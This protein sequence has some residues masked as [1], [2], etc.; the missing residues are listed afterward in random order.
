M[1]ADGRM[2]CP[3]RITEDAGGAFIMGFFGS[4][5]INVFSGFF[6]SPKGQRLRYTYSRV[7]NKAPKLGVAF[8]VWGCLF[9]TFD[10]ALHYI[11]E[12][13]DVL[14]TV[15][16]GGSVSALLSSRS[17]FKAMRNS[18]A[19]GALLM[20]MIEGLVHA[21]SSLM[22]ETNKGDITRPS[23]NQR[24]SFFSNI[25]YK[26]H[27]NKVTEDPAKLAYDAYVKSN[28]SIFSIAYWKSVFGTPIVQAKKED[29]AYNPE[30]E[31]EMLVNLMR[32]SNAKSSAL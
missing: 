29:P 18:F 28:S 9:A 3:A 2:A 14:N 6:S 22:A 4:A 24:D 8:G 25:F 5:I 1:T 10:C 21:M 15:L 17:G 23:T 30:R 26:D 13:D 32:A 19:V 20:F 27:L 16:A 31:H 7:A 12:K 11:R